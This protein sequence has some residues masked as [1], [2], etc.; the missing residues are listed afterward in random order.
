MRRDGKLI[1]LDEFN[2]SIPD[3]VGSDFSLIDFPEVLKPYM[4]EDLM[5]CMAPCASLTW[6][7]P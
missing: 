2:A 1:N 5:K 4:Q 3:R 7:T 6:S